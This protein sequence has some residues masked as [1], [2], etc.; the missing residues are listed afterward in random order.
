MKSKAPV[1]IGSIFIAYLAFVAVVILF[2]EPK[3]EDMSWEDRQ[4]YNQSMVS[5]LQLGQTL[6]EVTQTLGKADFSEAKQ[7]HSHSLQVLFYRTHHSKSDGKTT[8]DEC[9]PLL[10]EDGQ[11]LAWGEDTYQ[12]YL[13]QYSP[14]QVL[15]KAP[16]QPE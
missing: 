9:T 7:T 8:K 12:Q 2:Y 11:L 10:F 6:A 15:S 1:V 5:E 16:A 14:P 4:A 3:P 13:Q